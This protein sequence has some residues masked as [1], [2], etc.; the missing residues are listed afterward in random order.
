MISP[1]MKPFP[2]FRIVLPRLSFAAIGGVMAVLLLAPAYTHAQPASTTA[3]PFPAK[4]NSTNN[5]TIAGAFSFFPSAVTLTQNSQSGNLC[6]P[7]AC[8]AGSVTA[9][10]NSGWKLQV[11]LASNPGTFSV[12]YIQTTVP[13]TQQAVNAG[14]STPLN[15]TTWVTIAT[16]SGAT[17]GE[18]INLLFNARKASGKNGIVPTGAQLAAVIAYQ[19]VASP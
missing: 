13:P 9:K 14:T 15:T 19:V 17:S 3:P 6:S 16:G 10:G 12:N 8:Y 5:V 7:S 2:N 1:L 11:R 18:L 4:L